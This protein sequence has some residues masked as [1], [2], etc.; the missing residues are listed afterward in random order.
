[1]S[2]HKFYFIV[3][4]SEYFR[5]FAQSKVSVR[6]LFK[7]CIHFL[8]PQ[9][10][11]TPPTEKWHLVFLFNVFASAHSS[12]IVWTMFFFCPLPNQMVLLETKWHF[13][14][15]TPLC[16]CV[17][18]IKIQIKTLSVWCSRSPKW[19]CVASAECSDSPGH[20]ATPLQWLLAICP[21]SHMDDSHCSGLPPGKT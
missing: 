18:S 4:G 16:S 15:H 17:P 1:M 19:E 6:G 10:F 11:L 7:M 12:R 14:S 5:V 2:L 20:W 9:H 8:A 3:S 21:V 13:S